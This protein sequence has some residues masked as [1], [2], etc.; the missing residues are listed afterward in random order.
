LSA[1]RTRALAKVQTN[2]KLSARRAAALDMASV[3]EKKDKADIVEEALELRENLLGR[4]YQDLIEAAM[5]LR[6]ERDP[7]Q[8]LRA[9]EQLREEVTGATPGGSVTVSAAL[10]KIRSGALTRA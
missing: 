8:T 4:Q 7:E 6:V 10:A 1:R 9:L 2:L 5:R 3:L